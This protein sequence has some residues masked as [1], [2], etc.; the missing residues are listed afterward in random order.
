MDE[1][2]QSILWVEA[3]LI[4]LVNRYMSVIVGEGFNASSCFTFSIISPGKC[5]H[6]VKKEFDF[7]IK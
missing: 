5:E 4:L 3:N 2:E 1:H 7:R 6:I